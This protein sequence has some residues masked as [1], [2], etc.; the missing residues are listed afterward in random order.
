M[1]DESKGTG[2]KRNSSNSKTNLGLGR[3]GIFGWECEELRFGK[4][5]YLGGVVLVAWLTANVPVA[6]TS[7]SRIAVGI[8][9][10]RSVL[11]M[12]RDEKNRK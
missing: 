3:R 11:G 2:I 4:F 12:N 8:P 10:G 9:P 5:S 6:V 1:R 7:A